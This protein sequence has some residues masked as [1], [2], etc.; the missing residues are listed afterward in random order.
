M[1]L[2]I[3]GQVS[4]HSLRR[5]LRDVTEVCVFEGVNFDDVLPDTVRRSK[6]SKISNEEWN[7]ACDEV[8]QYYIDYIVEQMEKELKILANE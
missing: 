5:S 6:V 3:H 1:I 7:D 4:V 8:R 2:L